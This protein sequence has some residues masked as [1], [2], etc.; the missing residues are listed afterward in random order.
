MTTTKRSLLSLVL[1]A[2][3]VLAET[4]TTTQSDSSGSSSTSTQNQSSNTQNNNSSSDYYGGEIVEENQYGLDPIWGVVFTILALFAF[5]L[6]SFV[7]L[8]RETLAKKIKICWGNCMAR[9][10]SAPEKVEAEGIQMKEEKA[11]PVEVPPDAEK[12]A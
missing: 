1:L 6:C 10:Q 9:F 3:A 7:F 8:F 11:G 4:D 2:T 5:I 12:A